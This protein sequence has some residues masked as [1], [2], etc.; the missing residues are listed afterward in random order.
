MQQVFD[1]YYDENII[2]KTSEVKFRNETGQDG[3]GLTKEMFTLFWK[4]VI[5][6]LF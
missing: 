1:Y 5:K 3:G 2:K 6:K 4:Q